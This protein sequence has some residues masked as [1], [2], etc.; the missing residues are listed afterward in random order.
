MKI[1]IGRKYDGC[2][3]FS[4]RNI[5]TMA[6]LLMFSLIRNIY[7]IS[8][9]KTF[10]PPQSILHVLLKLYIFLILSKTKTRGLLT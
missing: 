9:K 8:E 7:Q 1:D 2:F 10:F 3:I 5:N 4:D 6:E